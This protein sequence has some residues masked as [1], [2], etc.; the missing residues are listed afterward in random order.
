[1]VIDLRQ[2]DAK[3]ISGLPGVLD[4]AFLHKAANV[5]GKDKGLPDAGFGLNAGFLAPASAELGSP[6]ICVNFN[7]GWRVK[8]GEGEVVRHRVAFDL[9]DD[10][11]EGSAFFLIEQG[12]PNRRKECFDRW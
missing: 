7:L 5:V 4:A 12:V 10:V 9:F 6:D 2:P 3:P 11:L 1:M 8:Q